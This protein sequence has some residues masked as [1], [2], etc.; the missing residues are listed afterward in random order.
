MQHKMETQQRF[1][2]KW[3]QFHQNVKDVFNEL[4]EGKVL[5]D[6]TLAC[7]DGI[8]VGA[9]R[10]ILAA[11]SSF[12]RGLFTE[13]NHSHPWIYLKGITSLE[14]KAVV[15]FMYQGEVN[16]PQ[17]NLSQFLATA[18]ELKVKGLS[19]YKSMPGMERN[20]RTFK[21]QNPGNKHQHL[22]TD[23]AWGNE[24]GAEIKESNL[25]ENNIKSEYDQDFDEETE[26]MEDYNRGLVIVE[27]EPNVINEKIIEVNAELVRQIEEN[28][29]QSNGT[30]TC[31]VC[32]K[33][34]KFKSKLKQ[35]VETHIDG[36]SH[37]CSLCGK[38][39]RSRNVL[40]MHMSRDHKNN[41]VI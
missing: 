21:D 6:V 24:I 7:N 1:C 2:L 25:I 10:I 8:Q 32:G 3:N 37:P 41:T 39:Y 22:E 9:H 4:R 35:H 27:E 29:V 14:L 11:C 13:N 12:F 36:F 38:S 40:G 28:L 15:D 17:D 23:T 16:V 30:W 5:F 19:G 34:A 26:E 20:A 33:V 31:K 18:E